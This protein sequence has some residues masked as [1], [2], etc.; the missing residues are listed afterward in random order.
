VQRLWKAALGIDEILVKDS[1]VSDISDR[2][3]IRGKASFLNIE[4]IPIEI[5]FEDDDRTLQMRLTANL[6]DTWTFRQS[7][8]NL[9]PYFNM[10]L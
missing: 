7:F 4:E 1:S 9:A 5:C 6:P 10:I 8:P 3:I 2:L